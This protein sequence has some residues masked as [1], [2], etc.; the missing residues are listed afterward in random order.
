MAAFF[1]YFLMQ[2]FKI[3]MLVSK[4][5]YINASILKILLAE[6]EPATI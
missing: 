1:M 5:M 6:L 3:F 4:I 2:F